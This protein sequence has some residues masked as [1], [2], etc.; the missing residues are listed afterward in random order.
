VKEHRRDVSSDTAASRSGTATFSVT[1]EEIDAR[2]AELD[3]RLKS[4]HYS[5]LD[6]RSVVKLAVARQKLLDS[7]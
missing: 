3:A 1:V 5:L 2:L 6:P 4:G 7:Q